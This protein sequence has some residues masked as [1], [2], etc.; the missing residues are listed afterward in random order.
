LAVYSCARSKILER[1]EFIS[2]VLIAAANQKED[3]LIKEIIRNDT[4]GYIVN[5]PVV[6]AFIKAD[7]HPML[8]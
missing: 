3:N 4:V 8:K 5:I 7:L 1:K 2:E 6:L